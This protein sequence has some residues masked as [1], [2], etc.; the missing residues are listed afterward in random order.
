M[1]WLLFFGSIRRRRLRLSSIQA[2]GQ[3]AQLLA[4][5]LDFLAASEDLIAEFGIGLFEEGHLDLELFQPFVH[6][7]DVIPSGVPA[8]GAAIVSAFLRSAWGPASRSRRAG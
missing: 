3:R 5:R 4:Q 8:I 1:R 2:A 6:A 7:D